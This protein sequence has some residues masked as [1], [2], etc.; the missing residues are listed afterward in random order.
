MLLHFFYFVIEILFGES[1]KVQVFFRL[2]PLQIRKILLVRNFLR[3]LG[4]NQRQIFCNLRSSVLVHNLADGTN[5]VR[6]SNALNL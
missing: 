2:L 5:S 3:G 6:I 4:Q 1:E